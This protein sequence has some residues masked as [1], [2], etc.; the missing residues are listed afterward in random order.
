[1]A[2]YI[3]LLQTRL[4]PAQF[5]ALQ[6]VRDTARAHGA[7]V[8]LVGGSVRDLTAGFSVR[9]LDFAVQGDALALKK[10][11]QKAG[12]TVVGEHSQTQALYLTYPGGVRLEVGSTLAAT[13]P[14]PGKPV[15]TPASILDDLRR[16]DFTANAMAVSLNEGSYGLLMDPLN[17]VA[18][19]ENMELRLV[20][21]YGFIEE[22]VRMIR[23][24]RLGVRLGWRME[25]K[26]QQRY[27][28]G[29]EEGYISTLAP[30]L[31]G[32]ELEEVFHEEDPLRVLRRLEAEGWMKVL[33]PA[34]T[35]AKANEAELN[36]LRDIAGQL[37]TAGIHPDPS[38]AY[39]PLLT[40]KLSAQ[41]VAELKHSFP[42]PGFVQA[43]ES[44]DTQT[45]AFATEFGGKAAATPSSAWK[46]LY[47][48]IPEQV[49]WMAYSSRSAPIQNRL[50]AFLNESPQAR[51][52]VP[53]QTMQEMRITPDLPGYED[54]V[55]KLF[56]ALMDGQLETTDAIK[57][58]LEPY[59]PPA[60]PPPVTLRRRPAKR[61]SKATRPKKA[62]AGSAADVAEVASGST[63]EP[64]PVTLAAPEP[65]TTKTA[66]P[67]SASKPAVKA[68]AKTKPAP[69]KKT[70]A[71]TK[72]VAPAPAPAR[73]AAKKAA[74]AKPEAI[75]K[76][77]PV[78]KPTTP[79]K[80]ASKP[81]PKKA[82]VKAAKKA[83]PKKAIGKKATPKSAKVVAVKKTVAKKAAP[84]PKKASAQK[85]PAKKAPA[86]AVKKPAKRR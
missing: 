25:E 43:I 12:F 72:A 37:E 65:E 15:Y 68:A 21:N 6:S 36:K 38:A 81:A 45:K 33:M 13:W 32:Y 51:Q 28:T 16:R 58:F 44:L 76:A 54:L 3:Y 84:Q 50:R 64:A 17:G 2:D 70:S 75:K 29:K 18:D 73:S 59:S 11:L 61:E 31:R 9:D 57:A 78:K 80:P 39:F 55:E 86:K 82:P 62:A 22:P 47:A 40:A 53:Y 23:A 1:M 46:T 19:I 52:R 48:A 4:T 56:F 67:K 49:L 66:A 69:V 26:T 14:K 24:A 42:R 79:S 35:A 34:W 83:A 85:Q 30:W 5:A 77:A 71:P 63:A 7:T 41:E 60:P 20:S 8:F 10:D 74:P 27:D